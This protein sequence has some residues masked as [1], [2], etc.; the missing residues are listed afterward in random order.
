MDSIKT[1]PTPKDCGI[2]AE[3]PQ[4]SLA[5]QRQSREQ[6]FNLIARQQMEHAH[7]ANILEDLKTVLGL[8]PVALTEEQETKVCNIARLVIRSI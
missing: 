8:F 4:G 5:P 2:Q 1:Y 7:R 6:I 3:Q